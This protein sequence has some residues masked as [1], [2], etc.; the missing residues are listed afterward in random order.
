MFS[1]IIKL[2]RVLSSETSPLQISSAFALA[3]IA[4]L[5]PLIS[6]HNLLVI[7]MLLILRVNIAAFLLAL[8]FFSGIAY[9][10]DPA[11]HTLGNYVLNKPELIDLWTQ[12]YNQTIWRLTNFNNTIVMGSL[13]V[14]LLAFVPILIISNFLIK[15]YRSDLL[16]YLDNSRIF[17]LI[18]T[19][20]LITK[21]VALAE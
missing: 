12:F 14:S 7:F 9:L 6:L 10:L 1:Q 3:M 8:A 15:H 19:S 20:K 21:I 17:R 5:T 18:K 11:F 4:G 13:I 16:I 2:F